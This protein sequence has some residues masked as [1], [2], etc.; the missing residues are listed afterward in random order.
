[1]FRAKD[2]SKKRRQSQ[3]KYFLL[4]CWARLCCE[5]RI[6]NHEPRTHLM[7]TCRKCSA[8]AEDNFEVC[9]SCGTAV[10]GSLDPTFR[11]FESDADVP[12]P[13]GAATLA[14]PSG[15]GTAV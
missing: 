14:K 12:G 7:W 3:R 10:D 2:G 6:T 1:M 4:S 11:R 9:W 5:Q 13:T 8:E 15:A